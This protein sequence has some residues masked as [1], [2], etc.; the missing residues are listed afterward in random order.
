MKTTASSATAPSKA[1]LV[2]VSGFAAAPGKARQQATSIVLKT[3][4]DPKRQHAAIG[5]LVR[6]CKASAVVTTASQGI[7]AEVRR[8]RDRG[9]E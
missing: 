8:D 1:G 5:K 2:H 7:T 9:H 3:A 4:T 6:M